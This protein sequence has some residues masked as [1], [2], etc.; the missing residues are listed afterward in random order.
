ML[1]DSSSQSDFSR[2]RHEGFF[3]VVVFFNFFHTSGHVVFK[4]SR[5]PVLAVRSVRMMY[6]TCFSPLPKECACV[7]TYTVF[8]VTRNMAERGTANSRH[9]TKHA[10]DIRI[11]GA[12]LTPPPAAAENSSTTLESCHDALSSPMKQHLTRSSL[13]LVTFP[14]FHTLCN[15]RITQI[16]SR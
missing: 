1:S 3:L 9:D 5:W 10:D 7:S 11:R 4:P 15:G 8:I 14:Q 13:L 16:C 6:L 2:Q 12:L